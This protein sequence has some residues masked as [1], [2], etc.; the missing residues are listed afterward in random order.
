MPEDFRSGSTGTGAHPGSGRAQNRYTYRR[1]RR[2][3]RPQYYGAVDLGTNNCRLLIARSQKDGFRIV[4]SFSRVVRLGAG[5]ASTGRLSEQSQDAAVEAIG[6]CAQKMKDKGVRRW[7][8]IATQACRAA[9]NGEA[10]LARV[11][12]ET[13]LSF[14]TISP[15][16]EAR[17]S[18]MGCLNI[19]DTSKDVVLVV[20]IG[21]GSTELSWVD[22]RKMRET[23]PEQHLR[24][25]PIAAWASLP[26][27]V[28]NLSEMH[29]ETPGDPD[30]F[31]KMKAR[32]RE[33]IVRQN[34]D[35]QFT[36]VFQAGRGHIIGTSG[37]VTS[38]ASVLMGLTHYQRHKID[39]IW[40]DGQA[41][42]ET[43]RQLGEMSLAERQML[44]CIGEDRATMILAGCAILEVIYE[45]WPS[46]TIRVADRGLREGMLMGLMKKTQIGTPRKKPANVG[47]KS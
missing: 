10:F 37:T 23:P 44:P 13:G 16:V 45:L 40:V 2:R 36:K 34:R 18:V 4:D 46:K 24:R 12:Q 20:D 29:P 15:R 43:S 39:G 30:W 11:K 7:R 25:P 38:L 28:V 5:L 1:R 14:E 22:A 47:R 17:L 19:I 31:E 41:M 32:V 35:T 8:C 21:G 33:E 3:A 9:E 6:I 27:G 42:M 26:V